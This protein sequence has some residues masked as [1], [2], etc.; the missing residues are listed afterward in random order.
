MSKLR[1]PKEFRPF[2]K[3]VPGVKPCPF[4]GMK[5]LD[6]G[7]MGSSMYGVKCLRCGIKPG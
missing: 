4:C 1:L 2:V 5:K 7:P 6:V 3:L